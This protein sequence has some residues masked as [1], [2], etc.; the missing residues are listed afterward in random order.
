MKIFKIICI[1]ILSL[2]MLIGCKSEG[3]QEENSSKTTID[4]KQQGE[5][6][7]FD[8]REN[9]VDYYSYDT[10][11]KNDTY[12]YTGEELEISFDISSDPISAEFAL[13]VFI[14][15]TMTP[16]YSSED[17]NTSEMQ[18]LRTEKEKVKKNYT[19]YFK[20][21]YGI[22]G[23]EYSLSV[24]L[25]DN[26]NYMLKD[27]SFL[28]F[29]PNHTT[30]DISFKK[31]IYNYNTIENNNVCTDYDVRELRTEVEQM[32]SNDYS[33]GGNMLNESLWIMI[34]NESLD[35]SESIESNGFFSLNKNEKKKLYIPFIGKGGEYRVS[36][37]INYERIPVFDGKEY[38]DVVVQ[39]DKFSEKI[40]ELDVSEYSGL[41]H[42]ELIIVDK[43]S[44]AATN[45]GPVL[46][47]IIE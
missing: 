46:L 35:T 41:N 33:K 1:M 6:E 5:S 20:P 25:L 26:P 42:I 21:L 8:F 22:Q 29:M 10:T 23:E 36:L 40:I 15:G 39:R 19:I 12:T 31:L 37:Y 32:Y 9:A 14:D 18:I 47:E 38:I 4:V 11:W 16:Y 45:Q 28:N 27:K 43:N 24:V 44:G 34:S 13:L 3:S 30:M 2:F 7:T 17:S